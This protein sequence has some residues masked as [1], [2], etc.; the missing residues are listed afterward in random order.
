M[1]SFLANR[2][3]ALV[4]SLTWATDPGAE[5]KSAQKID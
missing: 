1:D 4:H 5:L 2:I 3:R